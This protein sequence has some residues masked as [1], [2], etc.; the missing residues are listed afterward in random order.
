MV[1]VPAIISTSKIRCT[2][3]SDEQSMILFGGAIAANGAL[4]L[5]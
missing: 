1:R 2:Q 5:A 3:P 4:A